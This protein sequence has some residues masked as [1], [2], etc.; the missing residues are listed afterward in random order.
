M[1]NSRYR[2]R[3]T[4]LSIILICSS[5]IISC[6]GNSGDPDKL[7]SEQVELVRKYQTMKLAGLAG[8]VK[9]FLSMRDS[10]TNFEIGNYHK[11]WGWTVDSTKVVKWTTNWP[12]VA[13]LPIIQDTSDGEW[14]RIVFTHAPTILEDGKEAVMCVV[15]ILRKNGDEWKVSNVTR[16]MNSVNNP[17]GSK[18]VLNELSF[19][20]LFRIPPVFDDLRKLPG[21]GG[22]SL[23]VKDEATRAQPTGR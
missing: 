14:R 19:H 22:D 17:D 12:D 23:K 18:A 9:T 20:R 15:I 2:I 10:V 7:S 8:D 1:K 6:G 3:L 13:G 4:K 16:S 11:N 21:Q 5:F